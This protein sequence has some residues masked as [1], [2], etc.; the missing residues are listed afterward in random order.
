MAPLIAA[1][2]SRPLLPI[3]ETRYASVAWEM[4]L[5]GSWL[6]PYVNGAPYSD[7]PPL[8]FWLT[9][10][11]WKVLG[12]QEWWLRLVPALFGLA[13]VFL[14]R[15]LA[16]R[17]WPKRI[18]VAD[19]VPWILL[20]T[21]AWALYSTLVMFDMLVSFFTLLALLGIVMAWRRG[22]AGWLIV[23]LAI[24]LGVLSKGPVIL[25][26]VL[27][28]ALAA[29]WWGGGEGRRW[30]RWYL[31]LLGAVTLGAA[32]GMVWALPASFAGGTAYEDKLLWHQTADRLVHAAHH[33]RPIWWYLP[34]LPLLA[35]PWALSPAVWRGLGRLRGGRGADGAEPGVRF[36]LAW[37]VPALVVFSL[38]SGKQ[39]HYLLPAYPAFALLA[40]RA[41]ADAV[42]EWRL[43]D[44][45][46]TV[47]VLL[48]VALLLLAFAIEEAVGG[49]INAQVMGWS[50]NVSPIGALVLVAA[51]L[52]L[53]A[54]RGRAW[55][56]RGLA[57][58]SV[59]WLVV[60]HLDVMRAA[61]PAYD[62]EPAARVLGRLQEEG[63][64]IANAA[65]YHSQFQFLGRLE[66]PVEGIKP[67]DVEAWAAAHPDGMVVGYH[68]HWPLRVGAQPVFTQR[69]R[70]RRLAVWTAAAVCEEPTWPPPPVTTHAGTDRAEG[71]SLQRTDDA[72]QAPRLTSD[73]PAS[74]RSGE[75]AECGAARPTI[76][77]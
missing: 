17:L 54:L 59:L 56:V 64:P 28:V 74:A 8:L 72:G 52:I 5:R 27:P 36:C 20:G 45:L 61:A 33:R 9:L 77:S 24:G 19:R 25:L 15:E 50:R 41:L 43:R 69:Y 29:P 10:A 68:K 6:V 76:G 65:L 35:F 38:I 57:L 51:A 14:A 44:H 3:D 70:G 40:A 66:Q 71:R 53:L 26:Y 47:G 30:S 1:W 23:G 13:A 62:V 21:V 73:A 16:R 7:K 31:G 48:L 11:G 67:A 4:W 46:P 32:I 37:L 42:G 63:H 18:D 55:R 12:V 75:K 22:P 34:L 58:A 49:A 60:L 2:A 39:A